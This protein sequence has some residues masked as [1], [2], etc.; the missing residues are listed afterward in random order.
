MCSWSKNGPWVVVVNGESY[1]PYTEL[2][3]P[4][5][6]DEMRVKL[7]DAVVTYKRLTKPMDPAA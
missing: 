1:G 5:V 7:P 6:T 2:Q 3:A 4:R